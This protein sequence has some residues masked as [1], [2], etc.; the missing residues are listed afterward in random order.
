MSMHG[1]NSAFLDNLVSLGVVELD[2]QC[3]FL[4]HRNA[5]NIDVDEGTLTRGDAS[6]VP[7]SANLFL[8]ESTPGAGALR[9]M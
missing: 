4:L 7:P 1:S 5:V 8:E 2:V 9:H 6:C 3:S